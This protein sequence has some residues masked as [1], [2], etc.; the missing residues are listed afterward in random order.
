M[1]IDFSYYTDKGKVR[2]KNEDSVF[3]AADGDTGIFAVADGMGGHYGGD[4]AGNALTDSIKKWWEDFLRCRTDFDSAKENLKGTICRVNGQLYSEYAA[5]GTICGTTAAVLLVSGDKYAAINSGDSRIYS[6]HFLKL[7]QESMD[8][9]VGNLFSEE[10]RQRAGKLISAVGCRES[11]EL[12]VRTGNIPKKIT[13]LICSDGLYRYNSE[14]DI[15]NS[16][17]FSANSE[18]IIKKLSYNAE[19]GGAADNYSGIAVKIR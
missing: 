2:Q 17:L 5:R 16:M 13:F 4:I 9:T 10:D 8:Q 11:C 7:R 18:D 12:Y 3:A 6:C 1:A 19:K 14:A 15:R